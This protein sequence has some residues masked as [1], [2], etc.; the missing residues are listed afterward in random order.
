[1]QGLL[2]SMLIFNKSVF[3]DLKKDVTTCFT[4]ASLSKS[5]FFRNYYDQYK[6]PVFSLSDDH[7]KFI[8]DGYFG[9]RVECFKIGGILNAYYYDF[10]SLYPDVGRQ[11]LPYGKPV[12]VDFNGATKIDASFFGFVKCLVKT[13]PGK[14]SKNG[15]ARGALAIPKHA[16]I[17]DSRLTFP[18]FTQWAPISCFSA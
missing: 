2:E 4:G 15:N 7:D 3:D 9:G 6:I 5:T 13:K 16:V 1:M 17:R 11:H 8:R 14:M 18:I 10:T 12:E